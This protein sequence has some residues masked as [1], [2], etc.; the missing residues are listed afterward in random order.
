MSSN[1]LGNYINEQKWPAITIFLENEQV[2]VSWGELKGLL[3]KSGDK[4][5]V[6]FGALERTLTIKTNNDGHIELKNGSLIYKKG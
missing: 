1:I 2:N 6:H 3:L 4:Y 5:K